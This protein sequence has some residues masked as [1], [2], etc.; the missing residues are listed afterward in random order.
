MAE[1][2]AHPSAT[3]FS[4]L[5]RDLSIELKSS[6]LEEMRLMLLAFDRVDSVLASLREELG[7][8][9]YR[10]V[11]VVEQYERSRCR[12]ELP[13]QPKA[14][15]Y[16]VRKDNVELQ[17]D[18][19]AIP[20]EGFYIAGEDLEQYARILGANPKTEEIVLVWA[21]EE[22]DSIAFGLD[23]VRKWLM[24]NSEQVTIPKRQVR[25]LNETIVAVF[26]SHRR[27]LGEPEVLR[28]MRK[29]EFDLTEAFS[30][31]LQA[32]LDDLRDSAQRR[33]RPDRIMAIH[34]ISESDRKQIE[35]IFSRSQKHD[36]EFDDLKAQ[37]QAICE[38]VRLDQ[39]GC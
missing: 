29:V 24:Q 39:D 28:E 7:M 21:T 19:K 33:Q 26:D 13:T 32:K 27:V 9:V 15:D 16:I 36:L 11:D 34:S 6:D 20:R 3:P 18:V 10:G 8:Q 12:E 1:L 38:N 31:A 22:L 37:I 30:R 25:P 14:L 35:A 4:K 17:L 5:L 23:E 2:D